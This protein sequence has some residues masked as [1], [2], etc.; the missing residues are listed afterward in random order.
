MEMATFIAKMDAV[1]TRTDLLLVGVCVVGVVA[2]V[3]AK[4]LGDKVTALRVMG[5][6][7]ERLVEMRQRFDVIE[8]KLERLDG[9]LD[10]LNPR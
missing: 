5:S 2:I 9:K 10:R 6:S 8:L 7:M 3:C 4:M 1:I